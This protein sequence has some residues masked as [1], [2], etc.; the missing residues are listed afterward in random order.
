M[1][2]VSLDYRLN[3]MTSKFAAAMRRVT[4]IK[5]LAKAPPVLKQLHGGQ[6]DFLRPYKQAVLL[7]GSVSEMEGDMRQHW[8]CSTCS[9]FSTC[10]DLVVSFILKQSF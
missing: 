4:S 9:A 3:H 6:Q 1:A 10:L 8:S 2:A 7:E 5:R